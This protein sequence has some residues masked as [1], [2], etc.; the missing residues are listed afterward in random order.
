MTFS[1]AQRILFPFVLIFSVLIS[2]SQEPGQV[3]EIHTSQLPQLELDHQF[4]IIDSEEVI[5]QQVTGVKSDSEGRI[6]LTDQRALQIHVFDPQGNY[7]TS[8]GREGSGPGEFIS[9]MKIYIDEKDQVF[10]VDVNQARNTIFVENNNHWEP[11]QIFTIAGQRYWIDSA[12]SDGNVVLR[13]S[14]PQYP[15][16]GAF[17][18]EHEIAKGNLSSGLNEQE[19]LTIK[20]MGFLSSGD[21]ALQRIPFGRTTVVSTD[22]KGNIYLV[23]NEKFE[24]AKYNAKMEFIDSLNVEIPNQSISNDDYREVMDRV[25]NNFRSLARDHMPDS[26]PVINNMFVDKNGNIWLQTFDSPEYLVL[27]R[28]GTPLKSF[29]LDDEHRLVHVDEERIYTI[30]L[31]DEGYQIHVLKYQL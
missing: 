10:A 19:V 18:Y 16:T 14:P 28:G 13:Q 4:I 5:M 29:D 20:D 2:C 26:K 6:F 31:V 3:V 11:E 30:K 12:D 24:M 22:I 23:W 21:G 7:L 9:L 8:I 1:G 25:R 15:E 17:W 27:E